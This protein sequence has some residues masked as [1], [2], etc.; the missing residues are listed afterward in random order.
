LLITSK[1]GS[2]SVEDLGGT[3]TLGLERAQASSEHGLSDEGNR[4][5]EIKGIDSGPFTSTLLTS[6]IK[7]LL[8][9][10]CSILIILVHDV[11]SDLDEERVKDAIVPFGE[12]IANLLVLHS[13]TTLHDVVG[14]ADQLHVAI[15]NTVVDHLDVVTSTLVTNPLAAGFAVRFRGDGLENILDV[16]PRL[17]VTTRHNAGAITGA[18]FTSRDTTAD[19]TNTLFGQ[20]LCTAVGIGVVGVTTINDDVTLLDATLVEEQLNEVIDRLSSHDEHHH[21]AGLL[22]LLHELLDGVCANNRLALSLIVQEP[23]DLCDGSIESNN[24]ESMVSGIEDQ[25][26]TH[27]SKADEA[28]IPDSFSHGDGERCWE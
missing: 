3:A 25:V 5:T 19:K 28:E 14:F 16:W 23:I 15:L 8:N 6:R 9:N 11:A 4:H 13:E 20:V 7:N 2:G 18:L 24:S 17:L 21:A 26:L 10:G 12:N 27:D 1:A 22:Q